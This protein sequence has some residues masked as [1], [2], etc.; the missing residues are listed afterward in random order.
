[1]VRLVRIS[2]IYKQIS[3]GKKDSKKARSKEDSRVGR[4]M[5]DQATKRLIMTTFMLIVCLPMFEADFWV[6]P[7]D[8]L[9]GFCFQLAAV[10][11]S[12]SLFTNNYDFNA[13][14][15][16]NWEASDVYDQKYV[17]STKL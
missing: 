10:Y 11:A 12:P 15:F 14:Q 1:M 16:I 5:S 3:G 9:K 2:K 8:G 17:S 4:K 6:S 13:G 7:G